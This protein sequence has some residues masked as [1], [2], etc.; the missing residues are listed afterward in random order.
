MT[1]TDFE[2][3][4]S[5]PTA[6]FTKKGRKEIAKE[7]KG[8]KELIANFS[9]IPQYRNYA[10]KNDK[11]DP[12]AHQKARQGFYSNVHGQGAA[13]LGITLTEIYQGVKYTA[14]R[15]KGYNTFS[16][17]YWKDSGQD[18]REAINASN[19]IIQPAFQSKADLDNFND[20]LFNKKDE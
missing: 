3:G 8:Y 12:L 15:D 1:N 20:S 9:K 18:I 11:T 17:T 14:D 13:L 19:G 6:I 16:G 5:A 2:G 10:F 4:M 7:Y